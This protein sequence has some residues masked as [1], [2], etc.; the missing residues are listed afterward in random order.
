MGIQKSTNSDRLDRIKRVCWAL[1]EVRTLLG[2]IRFLYLFKVEKDCVSKWYWKTDRF[3]FSSKQQ[4]PKNQ[5]IGSKSVSVVIHLVC[6]G[7]M[8]ADRNGA[9]L[10]GQLVS[11]QIQGYFV[12]GG[13]QNRV[14]KVSFIGNQSKHRWC[15]Y[16]ITASLYNQHL[17]HYDGF[18]QKCVHDLLVY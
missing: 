3:S 6:Y 10:T 15:D 5:D 9:R 4:L 11:L 2:S 17:L 18:K 1:A 12:P 16:S 7:D 8:K 14:V 13:R